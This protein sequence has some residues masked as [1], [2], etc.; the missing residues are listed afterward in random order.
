VPNH[1]IKATDA[2]EDEVAIERHDERHAGNFRSAVPTVGT[3][4]ALQGWLLPH[5]PVPGSP[6]F[7][8]A[9]TMAGLPP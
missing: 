9:L 4:A 7:F 8:A 5:S 3:A 6:A 1:R 2:Q